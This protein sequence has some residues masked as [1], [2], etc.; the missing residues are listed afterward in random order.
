M[1][2]PPRAPALADDAALPTFA[3]IVPTYARPARLSACLEALAVLDYPRDRFAVLV[4][5]DGSPRSPAAI[6]AAFRERLDV[7]LLVRPHGGPAA[8]RNIGAE[9]AEG[10]FLAFT[11]DDCTPEPDWLRA[12]AAGLAA[13]PDMM[14]GGRTINR[15]ADN[16]YAVASQLLIDYLYTSYNTAAGGARFFA[17]NNL[18]LSAEQFRA[19]GGFDTRFPRAAGEDRELCDRWLARGG[20]LVYAP[21]AIVLHAHRLTLR[22]F[23]RQHHNYG[24]GAFHF[25]R[26]RAQRDPTGRVKIEP[27]VFYR[28]LV[29]YPFGRVRRSRAWL[30]AALLAL[31]QI[32]NALG[33]FGARAR[34]AVRQNRRMQ[35]TSGDNPTRGG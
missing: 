31:S 25:H 11:D 7:T 8:A 23:W 16:P 34:A 33:F 22:R 18:A 6:I 9:H 19:I 28:D 32:A 12:L 20:R 14:V 3:V 24:G 1:A 15:L 35:P 30:L 17:S 26:T 27:L 4:V 13:T 29:L 10:T 2:A 21:E 5:D